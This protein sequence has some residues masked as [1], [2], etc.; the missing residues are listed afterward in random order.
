MPSA[1]TY[2]AS[3][4]ALRS[5]RVSSASK[6]L[7][8]SDQGGQAS[9][10]GRSNRPGWPH[11][12]VESSASVLWLNR[13]TSGFLVNH[14]THRELGVGSANRHSWLGSHVVPARPW[15]WGST[16]KPSTTSSHSSCHHAA[17]TWLRWPPGPSN[18]AYLSSPNLEASPVTTLRACSSPAPTPVKPQPAPTILSQESVHAML[19]ITHHTRK[20]PSTSP[21]TTHGPQHILKNA[22]ERLGSVYSKHKGFKKDFNTLITYEGNRDN[23]ET[24]WHLLLRNTNS[25]KKI[26][27]WRECSSIMKSG[28]SHTSWILFLLAWQALKGVRVQTTC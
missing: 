17:R 10:P 25:L 1:A 4:Q 28:W 21:R 12:L 5:W 11:L 2:L 26:S 6:L 13:V 7:G 22:K 27:F 15:F 23:F 9:P 14:C 16:K 8:D 19:S 3:T 24:N 20:R 18:Q